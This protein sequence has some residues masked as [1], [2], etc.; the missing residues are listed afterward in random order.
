MSI[1]VVWDEP[2]KRI[3]HFV[4]RPAWTEQDFEAALH[5]ARARLTQVDHP[6]DLI[7][8]QQQVQIEERDLLRHA[9]RLTAMIQHTNANK[10]VLLRPALSSELD[11]MA[12]SS[13]TD[14]HPLHNYLF[15]ATMDEAYNLL[16]EASV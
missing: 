2:Q 10:V 16:W 15:A 3:I 11:A 6:V 13:P 7:I 8:D 14:D 4:Y 1:F 12:T 9:R 5:R